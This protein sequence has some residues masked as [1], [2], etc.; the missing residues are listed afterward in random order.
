VPRR[1]KSFLVPRISWRITYVPEN[2]FFRLH[3]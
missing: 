1:A 3:S 2:L